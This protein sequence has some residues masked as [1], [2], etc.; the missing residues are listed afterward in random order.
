MCCPPQVLNIHLHSLPRVITDLGMEWQRAEL[1]ELGGE[2]TWVLKLQG[3]RA[4]LTELRALLCSSQEGNRSH[5]AVLVWKDNKTGIDRIL[6]C[7]ICES[8][9]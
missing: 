7:Y 1:L 4:P 8:L 2:G 9:P 3:L 6:I 5:A